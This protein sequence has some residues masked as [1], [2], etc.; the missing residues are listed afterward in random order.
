VCTGRTGHAETVRVIFEPAR[1]SFQGLLEL[2]FEMHDPTQKDRQG[3]D[4]GSQYRSAIFA[5]SD[6]Q[7]DQARSYVAELH[8][9][10]AFAGRPIVTQI[11][12][13]GDFSLAEPEHQDFNARHGRSCAIGS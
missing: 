3:P 8:E 6:A 13:A 11:E 2:F 7:L 1:V 9:R 5:A 10:G 4:V 12:P